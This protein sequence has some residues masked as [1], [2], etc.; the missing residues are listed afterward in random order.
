MDTLVLFCDW[1]FNISYHLPTL[2][3]ASW[4]DYFF[5]LESSDSPLEW[6]T[7]YR[8]AVKGIHNYVYGWEILLSDKCHWKSKWICQCILMTY[9]PWTQTVT[10]GSAGVKTVHVD[11][12]P[13][14][15]ARQTMPSVDC[16]LWPPYGQ[17]LTD[18]ISLLSHFPLLL[19]ICYPVAWQIKM[20]QRWLSAKGDAASG[21]EKHWNSILSQDKHSLM[22][23]THYW[24]HLLVLE[25]ARP[26]LGGTSKCREYKGQKLVQME[27]MG[28]GLIWSLILSWQ[29]NISCCETHYF[30]K[31]IQRTNIT[32]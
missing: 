32:N 10:Q 28:R 25:G 2:H 31:E 14:M 27:E 20:W 13:H 29:K 16:L 21:Y 17:W 5:F 19:L 7:F 11:A 26:P 15:Q 9:A 6:L 3:S 23:T 30:Y 22:A 4:W 8:S 1:R 18:S 12:A 24:F